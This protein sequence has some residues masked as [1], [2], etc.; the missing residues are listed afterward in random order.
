MEERKS[1][2]LEEVTVN[3]IE[4]PVIAPFSRGG[5]DTRVVSF[6]GS[7]EVGNMLAS[8][9]SDDAGK[10]GMESAEFKNKV[11]KSLDSAAEIFTTT[12]AIAHHAK[13]VAE[14]KEEEMT[15]LQNT[16]R[17]ELY[18]VEE[19]VPFVSGFHPSN[20]KTEHKDHNSED[21]SV[22]IV[23]TIEDEDSNIPDTMEEVEDT[24]IN[25]DANDEVEGPWL[26]V[27]QY[28]KAHKKTGQS[29]FKRK[30]GSSVEIF[31][32][33]SN[34]V[35]RFYAVNTI[36]KATQVSKR[37]VEY[38][39]YFDDYKVLEQ[40]FEH[41]EV[42]CS[43]G[44][45]IDFAT[46]L[47]SLHNEDINLVYLGS[48]MAT[49]G[50]V[51]VEIMVPCGECGQPT[52][53]H[54]NYY[55]LY[56][57]SLSPKIKELAKNYDATKTFEV[58]QKASTVSQVRTYSWKDEDEYTCKVHMSAASKF[59]D[60]KIS[61][62]AKK[63]LVTSNYDAFPENIANNPTKTV[64][65]RLSWL[66]HAKPGVIAD[67]L[68]I[69]SMS[70]LI[71]KIE[72]WHESNPL[73]RE[74]ISTEDKY[75]DIV[76]AINEFPRDALNKIDEELYKFIPETKAT[77]VTRGYKCNHSACGKETVSVIEK[78]NQLYFLEMMRVIH[79]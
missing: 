22:E 56:R 52:K 40:I 31:L 78:V 60:L 37:L 23:D 69:V 66:H 49:V 79:G 42:I 75:Q 62:L 17:E 54:V 39:L 8:N 55:E 73:R 27:N 35:M 41:S 58:L 47:K 43:D 57:D 74:M 21:V 67:Y 70:I 77:L 2:T 5:T 7:S 48:L 3:K 18:G 24:T 4:R 15:K 45:E 59:K 25:I 9:R 71:D 51:P 32:P 12:A 20:T 6:G 50:D 36:L 30:K 19:A 1:V 13:Q 72:I 16:K 14:I 38:G 61:E 44:H 76:E 65:D 63:W 46:W 29:F 68:P 28:S 26:K 53:T 34:M 33:V 64:A 10:S 11:E